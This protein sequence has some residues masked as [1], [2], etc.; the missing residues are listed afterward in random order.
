MPINSQFKPAWIG[1]M[2]NMSSPE[3]SVVLLAWL[4]GVSVTLVLADLPAPEPLLVASIVLTGLSR[5]YRQL[6]IAS[7]FALGF[8]WA[9]WSFLQFHEQALP[10][11]LEGQNL[12][13]VGVISSLPDQDE[14]RSRFLF[15]VETVAGDG[16]IELSGR[17]LQLSCYHCPFELKP[18]QKWRFT[19]RI[20]RPHGYA[21]WGAFDY[22]KYLFRHKILATG[23]VRLKSENTLLK[24]AGASLGL[25]AVSA[26]LMRWH[27]A[28]KLQ[29]EGEKGS[30][31]HGML[32]A[33]TIGDKSALSAE[34]K[35][36]FQTTGISH[37]M[38]ISG[39]HIGLVFALSVYFFEWALN[40]FSAIYY[41]RPRQQIVLFPSLFVAF[42]YA[43][44]AGFAVSTQR[45]LVMLCVY[46]LCRLFA[47]EVTLIKVLLIAASLILLFDPFSILDA[48]FWLSCSAV[49]I[50]ALASRQGET[51]SLLRLQ[52]LIWLGMMPL[53]A[54]LFGQV[55]LIS[56]FINLLMVPLFCLL[57][58]PLVFLSAVLLALGEP[59]LSSYLLLAI[60]ECFDLCYQLLFWLSQWTFANWYL[61]ELDYVDGLLV[62]LLVL[63]YVMRSHLRYKLY[64][65]LLIPFLLGL[66]YR[67]NS[68]DTG[69]FEVTLLDVG[70]GLSI[71]I[72]TK[73]KVTVYDTGPAYSSGFS[74]SKAVLLPYLRSQG[75]RRI[76]TL[77]ISHADNDHI[78]GYDAVHEA[79]PVI[80]QLSSRPDR[81]SGAE[82]CLSGQNWRVD[83]VRFE[84]LS[85][86]ASTPPGSN[87]L[88]C[89]LR[90]SNQEVS[91]LI[92]GDIERHVEAHLVA[93]EQDMKADILLVPHHGSK[94]SSSAQFIDL[95]SPTLGI[96]SAGYRNRYGHPHHDVVQ[97]YRQQEV[98]LASTASSGS[99]RITIDRNG[100]QKEAFRHTKQRFWQHQKK[101]NKVR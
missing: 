39:L 55:S 97:R 6:K 5:R 7:A 60:N 61:P 21:S 87:N 56:P 24:P 28:Q 38:A 49:L 35:Q 53:T 100:W 91:V 84:I 34:H 11:K 73:N 77:I 14:Q 43:A 99:L 95:V 48:G 8:V 101:P 92:T 74:A 10:A 86:S 9:C 85:P 57:L 47:R 13:I 79:Y 65:V 40:F 67:S 32:S 45:A 46:S 69:Q 96:I 12:S 23:Y 75:I 15:K 25:A 29:Q 89:V 59:Y 70:Q 36:V 62:M 4:A 18:Q 51:L 33:L 66:G 3:A 41:W 22:E 82:A 64:W 52:P 63:A 78:G 98:E 1:V 44:L 31:A 90:V 19:V 93:N 27:L 80:R 88:S 94:T 68:I 76:D 26:N 54:Q 2:S 58:I 83:G 72:Q 17:Q 71:V 30:V 81:V 42:T 20:K 50:I 16:Q 37:L